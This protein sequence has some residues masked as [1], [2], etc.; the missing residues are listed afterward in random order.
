MLSKD[1][2]K[3]IDLIEEYQ[4]TKRQ[5][6]NYKKYLSFYK[7]LKELKNDFNEFKNMMNLLNSYDLNIF[8]DL[9][10][11]KT[12]EKINEI[13]EKLDGLEV[14]SKRKLYDL[15]N[16][17]ETKDSRLKEEWQKK[18]SK[19]SRDNL[20]T[21]EI[22]KKLLSNANQIDDIKSRIKIVKNNWPFTKNDFQ[23]YEKA[24]EDSRKIIEKLEIGEDGEE[25]KEFLRSVSMGKA[26]LADINKQIFNWIRKNGF[27]QNLGV[28]FLKKNKYN[29]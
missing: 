8:D 17:I 29:F 28:K 13:L 23:S 26:T 19:I 4:K 2:T 3:T 20:N 27:D 7:I 6:N 21:L 12:I 1:L 9:D 24:I 11:K 18:V 25:I 5:V 16:I 10:F 22:V 14:P 15:S